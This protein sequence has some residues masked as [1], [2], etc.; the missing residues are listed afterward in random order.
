MVTVLLTTA[1]T[2]SNITFANKVALAPALFTFTAKYPVAAHNSDGSYAGPLNLLDGTATTPAH[3]GEVI[4]FFGTG[5]GPTNPVSPTGILFTTPAPLAQAVTAT[6]G[7][8]PAKVEGYLIYPGV[9][10]INLTVPDFADGD[11]PISIMMES[12]STQAG[13]MITIAR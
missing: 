6:V 3:P 9:Y 1:F 7:G 13:L 8:V 2:S 11:A 4:Q 12:V 10:Q 5:F